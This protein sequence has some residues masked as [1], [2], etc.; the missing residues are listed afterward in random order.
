MEIKE[1]LI[2]K[3]NILQ[4]SRLNSNDEEICELMESIKQHGLK[5]PVGVTETKQGEYELVWGHRRLNA[6][7]KLG[8]SKILAKIEGKL[9]SDKVI[10]LNII[11]N[12]QRKDI[13]PF[14]LGRICNKLHSMDYSIKEISARLSITNKK[15]ENSIRLFNKLPKEFIDEVSYISGNINKKGKIAA[16]TAN[17]I[18]TLRHRQGLSEEITLKL[19]RESKKKELTNTQIQLVSQLIQEKNIDYKSAI[20]KLDEYVI[21]QP[22]LLLHKNTHNKLKKKV[23][24]TKNTINKV[25]CNLVNKHF[26]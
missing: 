3:I 15:V 5:Q 4:N 2:N 25:I 19:L 21:I 16:T 7:K 20:K 18:L 11:E 1:I 23:S 26:S 12:I 8:W 9:S 17:T 13:T 6:I 22:Q 24:N 10:T 14:E